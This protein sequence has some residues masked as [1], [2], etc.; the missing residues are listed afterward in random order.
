MTDQPKFP[1]DAPKDAVPA[2][3]VGPRADL[4]GHLPAKATT[5]TQ[6]VFIWT[7]IVLVGIIFGI[8][9]SAG[10]MMQNPG[11][12]AE[13]RVDVTEVQRRQ[14]IAV[15][16][17]D[18]LRVPFAKSG[19]GRDPSLTYARDIR[20]ALYAK[21]LGLMPS[22]SDLNRLV[23][24]FMARKVGERSYAEIFKD[25]R[26]SQE[27][28]D[29]E[30]KLW[31]AEEFAIKA[32]DA[33]EVAAPLMPIA[34]GA[35]L[36]SIIEGKFIV[37]EVVLTAKPLLPEIKA[38]DPEIASTYEKLKTQQRF[39]VAPSTTVQVVA[40]DIEA[41]ARAQTPSDDQVKA[42]YDAHQIEFTKPLPLVEP[43]KEPPKEA[44]KP[45][46]IPLAEVA[47]GIKA[48]LR[49]QA[50]LAQA[51]PLVDAFEQTVEAQRLDE[52][53]AATFASAAQSA[54]L[55]V[56]EMEVSE[57]RND[58]IDLGRFG[59]LTQKF[60]LHS[61]KPG[62]ITSVLFGQGDMPL[63][64]RV[65]AYRAGSVKPLSDPEVVK[66]VSEQLAG[67][68]AYAL[69][70]SEAEQVRAA[71]EAAGPGGLRT[72]LGTDEAKKRWETTVATNDLSSL[73]DLT[74]PA[75]AGEATPAS[76][77]PRAL[78]SLATTTNPVMVVESTQSGNIPSVKLVQVVGLTVP[79]VAETAAQSKHAESLRSHIEGLLNRQADLAIDSKL[80]SGG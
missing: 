28:S 74:P 37:D 52:Q 67:Q 39:A 8:G 53:D 43:G 65:G 6:Q 76:R 60:R 68:R 72:V 12:I 58:T 11:E 30:L 9:P 38:D 15:L 19:Y 57:T 46:V 31:L 49:R 32:L 29:I 18:I 4:A 47:E 13:Y 69:L 27:L 45:E 55:V 54:K 63:L 20:K 33:R 25:N 73:T 44:P 59:T 22:G 56:T 17:Q 23:D 66:E 35:T 1:A 5:W 62:T 7:M 51:K 26:R 79:P 70:L 64:L 48:T 14:R 40:A 42:Y 21:D 41:L 78:A 75:P 80:K 50:A 61:A 34:A 2:P 3:E 36:H 10:L 24:E 77:E 16:L 71:A